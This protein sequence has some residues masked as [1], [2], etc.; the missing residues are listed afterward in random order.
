M[1]A[2]TKTPLTRDSVQDYDYVQLR[3]NCG[4][5]VFAWSQAE[6]GGPEWTRYD[7]WLESVLEQLGDQLA[8]S[9]DQ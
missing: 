8:A 1:S 6:S 4:L 2:S 7:N 5:G 3:K 9:V